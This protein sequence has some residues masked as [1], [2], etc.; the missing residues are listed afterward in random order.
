MSRDFMQIETYHGH[1]QRIN[2]TREGDIL[3]PEEYAQY[4]GNEEAAAAYKVD[5]EDVETLFGWGSRYSAPG[6]LDAT[7][8]D[9]VYD[10]EEEAITAAR[11]LYGSDDKPLSTTDPDATA[12]IEAWLTDEEETSQH[13]TAVHYEHGQHWV[14]CTDCG[15]SWSVA[16]AEPGPYC[17]EQI[18]N[19]N[20]SCHS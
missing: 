5:P 2:N 12:D 19:G 17:L 3:T 11:D 18:D 1:W 8:W 16:D 10:T 20:E 9:G 4:P 14:T 13:R 7:E 6:Y 15:A